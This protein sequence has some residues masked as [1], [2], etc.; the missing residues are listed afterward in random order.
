MAMNQIEHRRGNGPELF[1]A[2]D[3]VAVAALAFLYL[4]VPWI[5][6]RL[7]SAGAPLSMPMLSLIGASHFLIANFGYFIL[8]AIAW[9]ALRLVGARCG[10]DAPQDNREF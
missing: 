7:K 3:F 2:T 5:E 4:V 6:N 8:L 9:L 10:A 1:S